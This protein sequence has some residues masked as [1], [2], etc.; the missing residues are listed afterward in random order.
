MRIAVIGGGIFGT[1]AAIHAARA[2]HAVELFEEN[3]QLLSAASTI[4]QYRLH[5]GY[6][7]PRSPET[8]RSC[9]EAQASFR[10][11]YADAIVGDLRHFYGIAKRGS[12]ISSAQFAAFCEKLGLPQR[13]ISV[14]DV[15]D[16]AHADAFEVFE[17]SIDPDALLSLVTK[18]LAESGVHVHLGARADAANT[19]T[20]DKVILAAY[21]SGNRALAAAGAAPREYQFEVCEKPVVTLPREFGLTDIVILDGPFMS[22]GPKGRNGTYVLGHVTHAIHA[23]NVG[24]EPQVPAALRDCLNNGVIANPRVTNFER[25]IESGAA[26]IPPLAQARHIG[27]MYTVRAVLPGCEDTDER[28]T[29]VQRAGNRAIN[30]FSGKIV[31]CVEAARRALALI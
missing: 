31:N 14:P 9:I 20:F 26:F 5:R 30:I 15:I 11:E 10:D 4:N 2:G 6:H 8:A 27:S 23:T 18:K 25:F 16:P 24:L 28:P 17:A 12:L 21:A 22:V 13:A 29:L 7:Y 1:T 19:G 3:A